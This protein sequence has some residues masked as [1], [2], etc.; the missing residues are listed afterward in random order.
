MARQA[1]ENARHAVREEG[2]RTVDA[3]W[4]EALTLSPGNLGVL[5]LAVLVE[6]RSQYPI[7][8]NSRVDTRLYVNAS[9]ELSDEEIPAALGPED[10][11]FAVL[12]RLAA[13]GLVAIEAHHVWR[14]P[15]DRS[16]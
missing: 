8:T 12:R 14:L 1:E 6:V 3:F 2:G 7:Q 11:L 10:M 4:Y 5:H 16:S 13:V 15:L 9:P